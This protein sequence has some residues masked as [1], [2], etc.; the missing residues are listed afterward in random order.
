MPSVDFITYPLTIICM[1]FGIIYFLGGMALGFITGIV[2]I[3]LGL[4]SEDWP[5]SDINVKSVQTLNIYLILVISL[6]W[7]IWLKNLQIRKIRHIF[8]IE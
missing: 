8:N 1:E 3:K 4:V 6:T 2:T 5:K 7:T